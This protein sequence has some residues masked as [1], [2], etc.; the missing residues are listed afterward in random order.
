MTCSSQNASSDAM[1]LRIHRLGQSAFVV[2]LVRG[3]RSERATPATLAD[4]GALF[5]EPPCRVVLYLDDRPA[6]YA[7]A[8]P[9]PVRLGRVRAVLRR[10]GVDPDTLETRR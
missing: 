5:A 10:L 7:E 8:R 2:E 4:V 9:G 1:E 6:M 3:G